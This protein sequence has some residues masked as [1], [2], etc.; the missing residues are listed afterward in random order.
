MFDLDGLKAANDRFGHASG[1]RLLQRGGRHVARRHTRR[2]TL[3]PATAAT[4]SC[5]IL[6]ETDLAGAMLVAERCASISAA[7]RCRTTGP[8]THLGLDR[9]RHLPG[10]RPHVDRTDAPR[11]P[12]DVRGQAA[13]RA[14]R[15]CASRARR[16]AQAAEARAP[17][18]RRPASRHRRGVRLVA[19]WRRQARRL[20]VAAARD[21]AGRGRHRTAGGPARR[22]RRSLGD[23]RIPRHGSRRQLSR[24][25]DAGRHR[26]RQ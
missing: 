2:P 23:R 9:P 25:A 22:R 15:S 5:C 4:N 17:A 24:V 18:Q 10:R 19:A 8:D 7:W 14:I 26:S 12:G 11:R 16:T 6:P 21:R 13:R 1:D 3:P 20:P